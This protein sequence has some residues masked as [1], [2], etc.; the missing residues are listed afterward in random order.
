MFV[1]LFAAIAIGWLLGRRSTFVS[2]R[3][4]RYFHKQGKARSSVIDAISHEVVEDGLALDGASPQ[5][6]LAMGVQLRRRGEVDGAVR[7]HQELLARPSLPEDDIV[8]ARLE[9]AR[10]YISAGLLDRAEELLLELVREF[11]RQSRAG[12][13]HLLE[14]YE[15][16]RE[17]RRAID[18]ATGLLPRKLRREKKLHEGPLSQG[19]K[20][21]LRLAHYY[22]ELAEEERL[23][24]NNDAAS[25]LLRQALDYDRQC[26]R[27]A[28]LLGQVEYDSGRY[29][30]AAQALQRVRLQDPDYLPETITLLRKCYAALS[31]EKR[32]RAYLLECLTARSTPAL[33]MAV[34]QDMAVHEG[35]VA[36]S[37]FLT[38]QLP[39]S[40]SL[41]GMSQ[42]I[43]LQLEASKEA[44][45]ADLELL[46]NL[47]RRLV[48][49]RPSY[50]CNHCG[51]AGKY[52]HW[53]C[54][55]CKHWGTIKAIDEPGS[56]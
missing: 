53:N 29:Q 1:L 31:D 28:M 46:Q 2:R 38:Q 43:G 25:A 23:G 42:L 52:L 30:S 13:G 14:I 21:A 26:V 50:R 4:R 3:S 51:F 54:P 17:W 19:Q 24:G 44:P 47:T 32:L 34:A 35:G 12:Q 7:I 49:S 41:G 6:R 5:A 40:P 8:R 22:C 27:A 48:A 9:L 18:V 37:H 16:E 15:A 11:P 36:T 56:H 39:E 10:D 20:P 45:R 55:G 33:V